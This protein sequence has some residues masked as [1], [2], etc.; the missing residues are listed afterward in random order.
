MKETALRIRIF[1]DQALRK[2][3]K[4]VKE[5]TTKHR[6]YLSAMARLMYEGDGI[7]LAAP[8]VGLSEAM[9]VID[10]GSGLFKL[11]NPKIIKIEGRQVLEEGCL[12]V[13]GV[14]I[15]VKRAKKVK[16]KA[17]DESGRQIVIDAEDLFACV[18]QHEI[19]HLNGKLIVDYA[20]I[21]DKVRIKNKLE[22]L[23][24]K[25]KDEELSESETKSCQLQL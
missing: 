12:S 15:K 20:S 13:P 2:K 22:E 1:G 10:I 21:I 3:A 24:K 17:L 4:S 9:I 6:E 23:K 5:L 14:C 18:L 19:D 16:V 11:V 7:G 25:A 8:Q